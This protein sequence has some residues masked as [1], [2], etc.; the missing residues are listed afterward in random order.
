[1]FPASK[2]G[3][4]HPLATI[5]SC[6]QSPV[7]RSHLDLAPKHL[8]NIQIRLDPPLPKPFKGILASL[9]GVQGHLTIFCPTTFPHPAPTNS[10]HTLP[11]HQDGLSTLLW[12]FHNSMPLLI[13]QSFL[14]PSK[15]MFQNSTYSLISSSNSNS[16]VSSVTPPCL[17]TQ[18]CLTLCDPVDSSL[19]GSS[20]H[21]YSPG[22]N[23]GVGSHALLQGIFPT[24]TGIEPRTSLVSRGKDIIWTQ[25]SPE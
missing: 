1:M 3:I 4:H 2:S 6:L 11:S 24:P 19:P 12:N 18:L 22:K 8:P 10:P 21:G 23:T 5:A 9:L 13:S 15:S 17:V 20:V 25:N 16:I 14:P 7:C